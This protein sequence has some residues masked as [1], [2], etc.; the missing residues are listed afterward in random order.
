MN[1]FDGAF[2]RRGIEDLFA[3]F[4]AVLFLHGLLYLGALL[5]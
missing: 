5:C 2:V 3:F 4:L 1:T